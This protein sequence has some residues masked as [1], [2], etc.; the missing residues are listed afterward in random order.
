MYRWKLLLFGAGL[1]CVGI[2]QAQK[3][4][5]ANVVLVMTD[6]MRWQEIFRGA[7][8][9]L[10]TKARYYDG[11]KLFHQAEILSSE[12]IVL[13]RGNGVFIEI[14]KAILARIGMTQPES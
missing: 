6:G 12:G 13:A 9:S 8:E 3:P 7:D 4:N 5:D 2:A 14:D 1:I 11:R 10:L